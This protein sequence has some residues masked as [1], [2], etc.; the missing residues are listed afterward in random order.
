MKFSIEREQDAIGNPLSD[1]MDD[2]TTHTARSEGV[3]SE[4]V[5][6]LDKWTEHNLIWA[7]DIGEQVV[8]VDDPR[9]FINGKVLVSEG[10]ARYAV[11]A[12]ENYANQMLSHD[13]HDAC[14]ARA[15]EFRQAL[16]PNTGDGE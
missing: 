7:G 14:K 5:S 1:D 11:D 16:Q 13:F 12:L 8:R 2:F 9:E 10:A 3:S 4:A 6:S 15:E